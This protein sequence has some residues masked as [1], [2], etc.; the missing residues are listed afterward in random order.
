MQCTYNIIHY[1]IDAQKNGNYTFG[2]GVN[3]LQPE[4]DSQGKNNNKL[5]KQNEKSNI[6]FLIDDMIMYCYYYVK[7]YAEKN[8]SKQIKIYPN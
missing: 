6:A 4:M 2:E 7:K 5:I 3:K 8:I 1:A